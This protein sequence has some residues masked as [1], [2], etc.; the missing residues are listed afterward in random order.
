MNA[1]SLQRRLD[2]LRLAAGA[3]LF[4]FLSADVALAQN[5]S[6]DFGA[7]TERGKDAGTLDCRFGQACQVKMESLGFSVRV[8]ISRE[9]AFADVSMEGDDLGCCYFTN[10]KS[11]IG[12]DARQPLSRVPIFKGGGPKGGLFIQ[13]ERMGYLYL[14][15]HFDQASPSSRAQSDSVL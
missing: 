2:S 6:V 12:I 15:F 4:V 9:P 8:E 14:R 11:K 10:G 5:Y 13:N 7:D 3:A 1:A